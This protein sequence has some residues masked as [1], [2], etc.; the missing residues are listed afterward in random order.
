MAQSSYTYDLW[1]NRATASNVLSGAALPTLNYGYDALNRLKSVSNGSAAQDEGYAFDLF[2]N[3]SSKTLGTPV[4]STLTYQY[5]AAQQLNQIQQT[6]NSI[7][8]TL[9]LLRYDDNGNLKKLCDAGGGTVSGTATDCTASGAGSQTTSFTWDGLDELVALAKSGTATLN[10]AYAYDDAGR[11]IRKTSGAATTHYVYNGEDIVAEWTGSAFAGAPAA[12]YTHGAGTDDPLMRLTGA[13]GTPDAAAAYYAQDGIGSVVALVS[14]GSAANQTPLPANTLTTTGDYSSVGY[15]GSQ[16]NDG[17]TVVSGNSGWVGVVASGAA[18][19]LTFSSTITVEHV[20]LMGVSNYLPSSYVVEVQNGSG[21]WTPLASG[22]DADFAAW[23]DGSSVRAV[24]SFTPVAATAIRV[25]YIGAV[26]SGLV[27]LTEWQVW[28]A[29]GSA[30]TQ[31]FDAWGQLLQAT[32]SIPT[33]GYT[34]REPDASGLV[35]YRARYY[36]PGYGRFIKRDP[37]GLAA[38]INPYAYASGNPLLFNDPNG[39]LASSAWNSVSGYW[40]EIN[41]TTRLLGGLQA[42]GGLSEIGLGATVG[43]GAGWTGVGAVA[44]AGLIGLGADQTL[45]GL[46]TL[47]SGQATPSFVNQGMQGLGLSPTQAAWGDAAINL[48]AT[49][50]GT[51]LLRGLGTVGDV[52]GATGNVGGSLAD[53]L[54]GA[55]SRARAAVGEGSG[56]VYGTRV[57][58]A[59]ES[60]VNSLGNSSLSTEVSYLNGQVVPR[61]T[62][63]SVRL[64]VVNGP[65]DAPLAVYDL[66]TGGATLTPGRIQQIQSH[67]PGGA[68]VPVIL[69]RP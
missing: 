16:L 25:R 19:T 42:I 45:A 39:L 6:V 56:P 47:I 15:P 46:R 28:S 34:G 1:G 51:G 55:A 5:D 12:V 44:G 48:G 4:A 17:I 57:H 30:V 7:T 22:T 58:T 18:S 35:F 54:A 23:S 60:E 41:G 69:V 67:I 9:A 61:G 8:G 65:L 52:A 14:V 38:G 11:R 20:E 37:M 21:P 24:K 66:K 36:M 68:S 50:G 40:G 26:N 63:G 33:Y 10:E 62:P 59:F 13:S 27:W 64:D 32:G 29:G 2:G 43:V 49:F 53:D 3:R 31:Q